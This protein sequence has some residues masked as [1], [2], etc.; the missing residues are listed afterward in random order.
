MCVYNYLIILYSYFG[1]NRSKMLFKRED[2]LKMYILKIVYTINYLIVLFIKSSEMHFTQYIELN[3]RCIAI[4]NCG[5]SLLL[6]NRYFKG[7]IKLYI[8]LLKYVLVIKI[9]K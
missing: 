5:S 1:S 6:A 2:E 3:T 8:Y 9:I 7:F 4:R